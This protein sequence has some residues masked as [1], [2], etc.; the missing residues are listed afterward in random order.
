MPFPES[1]LLKDSSGQSTTGG[2]MLLVSL[3]SGTFFLQAKEAQG[4]D[5]STGEAVAHPPPL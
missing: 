2:S 3:L 1:G 4:W 5:R